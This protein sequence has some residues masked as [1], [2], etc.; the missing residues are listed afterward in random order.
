MK[1]FDQRYAPGQIHAN[2]FKRGS[3]ITALNGALR[4]SYR[5][6]SLDWLLGDAPKVSVALHEGGC[7]VLPYEAFVEIIATGE[8]AAIARIDAGPDNSSIAARAV[9]WCVSMAGFN[10]ARLRRS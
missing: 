6:G 3:A 4:L 1:T 10:G 2:W 5:D 9:R 8:S 7:H